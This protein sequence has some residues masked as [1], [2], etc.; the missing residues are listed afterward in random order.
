MLGTRDPRYNTRIS[1]ISGDAVIL[2]QEEYERTKRQSKFLTPA[3]VLERTQKEEEEKLQTMKAIDMKRTNIIEAEQK[4]QQ[5]LKQQTTQLQ[6]AEHERQLAIARSKANEELDEVKLMN[7][8][9]AAARVRAMRD[10]ELILHKKKK[11]EEAAM[12]KQQ[13]EKLE[14]ERQRAVQIYNE[15]ESALKEQRK[16]GAQ[17]ILKQI[18]DRKILAKIEADRRAKEIAE[19]KEANQAALEEEQRLAQE[20]KQRQQEFLQECLEANK[21]SIVRKHKERERDIQ[22]V[23]AII[24]YNKKKAAQEE[25]YERQVAERKAAKERE[26]SEIRKNQQRLIDTQ[27]QEDELRARRVSEEKER[28]ERQRE[29]ELAKKKEEERQMIID[30]RNEFLRLKQKRLI[31]LANIEKQEFERAKKKWDEEKAARE[32]EAARKKAAQDEYNRQLQQEIE[33]KRLQKQMAP[34]VHLDD[35]QHMAEER[36]D[37]IDRIEAIRQEKLAMLRAEGV[38][39]KY[40]QDLANKKFVIH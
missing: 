24:E 17:M 34:L 2:T 20:K 11:E 7:Q 31:Q 28:K 23:N 3:Q 39:E 38:P 26:I 5:M 21:Q 16:L 33:T 40:L 9:V 19:M 6:S 18:N 30:N 22:E 37:Y 25:E 8:E 4:H 12:E 10:A 32:A 35:Q 13:A 29:L 14:A 27:A 36:Q 1:N 15:R